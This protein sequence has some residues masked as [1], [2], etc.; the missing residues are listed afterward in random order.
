MEKYSQ[1]SLIT[2]PAD[3]LKQMDLNTL[4]QKINKNPRIKRF[5]HYLLMNQRSSCPRRWVKLLNFFLFTYGK[6]S[7]I[8]RSAIMNISPI[9][10]FSLGRNSVIEHYSVIDNGVGSVHIGN[11]TF[12]GLRNTIIGPV[13][14]GNKVILGQ[15]IV[16]SGLNHNY[17]D[18]E[19]SIREQGVNI[20][21]IHIEDE[22]WIGA[23]SIVTAGVRIGKHSIIGGGSVVTKSIPNY[24]IAAG[25]PAKVI[26]YYDFT[27]KEWLKPN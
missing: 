6:H 13:Q 15:N 11:D 7:I 4:K 21:T 10:L 3:R 5:I 23:N 25:N 14:I 26:K 9:N 16:L 19:R 24:S 2:L 12:I 18:I 17:L 1:A 8:K 27:K 22:S 20:S